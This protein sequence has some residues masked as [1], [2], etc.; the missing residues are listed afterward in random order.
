MFLLSSFQKIKLHFQLVSSTHFC[1]KK[2]WKLFLRMIDKVRWIGHFI[3]ERSL[4]STSSWHVVFAWNTHILIW[5]RTL[6]MTYFGLPRAP[7]TT[8]LFL[9]VR[10]YP[11]IERPENSNAGLS[12]SEWRYWGNH[13][14]DQNSKHT[15]EHLFLLYPLFRNNILCLLMWKYLLAPEHILR[16]LFLF[17]IHVGILLKT[18]L[19]P[20]CRDKNCPL[21]PDEHKILNRP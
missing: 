15:C 17:K 13:N 20:G 12:P 11:A 18:S 4:R 10:V 14:C 3:I 9:D 8:D 16:R 6:T 5:R 1:G 2:F 7:W 19:R 21:N